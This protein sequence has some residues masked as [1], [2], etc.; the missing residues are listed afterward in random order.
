[1]WKVYSFLVERSRYEKAWPNATPEQLDKRAAEIVRDTLPTASKAPRIVD[2]LRRSPILASFPTF[3]AEI[4][5]TTYK[6]M[7]L[8]AQE[9]QDIRTAPS[10]FVASW[11]WALPQR[12]RL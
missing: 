11:V 2:V 10:P 9:L 12:S 3:P 7:E 4:L 8:I 6:R 5:R 1:V